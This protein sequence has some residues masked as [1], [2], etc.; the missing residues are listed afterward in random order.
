ME[1][2]GIEGEEMITEPIDLCR[3]CGR[4]RGDLSMLCADCL[5]QA[6][7]AAQTD[8]DRLYFRDSSVREDRGYDPIASH[9]Y[10]KE[11]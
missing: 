5:K 11:P 4:I 8:N 9:R 2:N 6:T 10:Y 3:A 1:A 7:L